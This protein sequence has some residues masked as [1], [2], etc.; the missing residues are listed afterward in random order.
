MISRILRRINN[1]D[2][3]SV[4]V[5]EL[6]VSAHPNSRGASGTLLPLRVVALSEGQKV[7]LTIEDG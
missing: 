4:K 2:F 7:E 1:A 6:Y 5:A 3:L